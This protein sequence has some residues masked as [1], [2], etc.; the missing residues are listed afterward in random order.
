MVSRK[1]TKDYR[2]ENTIGP[3]GKIIT[4]TVYCGKYFA[5]SEDMSTLLQARKKMFVSLLCYWAFFWIGLVFNSGSMRQLYVAL[6]Y[7]FGFLPA[8]YLTSSVIY[9]NKYTR[10]PPEKGFTREQR[11]KLCDRM[12]QSSFAALILSVV[13]TVGMVIF[14]ILKYKS[15]GGLKDIVVLVS[16]AVM[17]TSTAIIFKNRHLI[18][19]HILS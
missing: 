6:P 1:Y 2:L 13:S 3:N 19:M 14:F 8:I 12:A 18:K 5:F 7:F 4:V 15:I 16:I 10:R 9:L 17:A 11:D